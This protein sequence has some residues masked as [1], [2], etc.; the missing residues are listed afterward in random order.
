MIRAAVSGCCGRMGS[1]IVEEIL[2]DP[3]RFQLAG[4]FEQAGHEK[5]GAGIPGAPGVRVQSDL[6]SHLAGVQSLI[7]FTTAGATVEHARYASAAGVPMVIGTTGFDPSQ[8]EELRSLAARIP[9]FWSANMSLGVVILRQALRSLA[10]GYRK[11]GLLDKAAIALSETHHVRKKD[12]P[13]GTAKLLAQEI[14]RAAGRK[15]QDQEI[16]ARRIGEVVGIHSVSFVT[17]AEKI[18]IQ[19][20]ALDRRLFAQGAL[21]AAQAFQAF[22][23]KPGWYEMDDLLR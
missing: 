17:P 23:K 19:H 12:K 2:K 4:A 22:W 21:W 16:E 11:F 1:L 3:L 13:S 8:M 10:D 15:I 9:I 6:A 18:S 5:L 20:E 7:E 14:F